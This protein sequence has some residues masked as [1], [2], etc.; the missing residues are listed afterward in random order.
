VGS[1]FLKLWRSDAVTDFLLEYFNNFSGGLPLK[2]FDN[3]LKYRIIAHVPA[4]IKS[5]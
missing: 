1:R 4:F 2:I 5:P 3:P